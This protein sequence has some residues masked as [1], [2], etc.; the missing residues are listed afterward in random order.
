[1]GG[2]EKWFAA[3]IHANGE[4][5]AV[6]NLERQGYRTFC[7]RITKHVTHARRTLRKQAPLFP[8]YLFINID[9]T[10]ARWKPVDSTPGISS[11]VKFGGRPAPLPEGLVESLMASVSPD[12]DIQ[13]RWPAPALGDEV[14]VVGGVFDDW[15]GKVVALPDAERITLLISVA[16]R[17]TR[18]TL[19]SGQTIP[20]SRTETAA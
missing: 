3:K 19:P 12:G 20:A 6:R 11:L 15:I 5:L 17:A 10:T 4:S 18:L 14:R 7:P 1:M 8:G 13:P 16:E 2:L 9:V